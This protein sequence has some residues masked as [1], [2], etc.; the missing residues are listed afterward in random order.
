MCA[1]ASVEHFEPQIVLV[2]TCFG[3]K[4]PKRRSLHFMLECSRHADLFRSPSRPR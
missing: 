4:T 3:R 2:Q 1:A